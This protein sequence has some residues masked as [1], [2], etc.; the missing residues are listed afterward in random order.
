M[1]LAK[2][3][4]PEKF[5]E[6]ESV[7]QESGPDGECVALNTRENADRGFRTDGRSKFRRKLEW[8]RTKKERSGVDLPTLKRL[9]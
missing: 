3:P 5:V 4:K 2:N 8:L 7:N 9:E 6:V 1:A